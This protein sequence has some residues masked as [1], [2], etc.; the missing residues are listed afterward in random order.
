MILYEIM[1]PIEH[2]LLPIRVLSHLRCACKHCNIKLSYWT[3]WS[4][5]WVHHFKK[6]R[7]NAIFHN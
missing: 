6:H 4:C 2:V 3:Y 1:K 5:W 7:F